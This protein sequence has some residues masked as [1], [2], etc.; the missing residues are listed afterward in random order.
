MGNAMYD[1]TLDFGDADLS[2]SAVK[3]PNVLDLGKTDADRKVIDILCA[4]AAGGTSLAV[5][6][7]GSTNGTSGW[8]DVGKNVISLT[9]LNA[10]NGAVAISPNPYRYLQVIFTKTGTFTA[11]NVS[12]QLNTL[13]TK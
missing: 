12:A 9:D 6:V 1:A 5:I 11:G 8:V 2:G 10:G 4:D 7:Q 3:F 13:I